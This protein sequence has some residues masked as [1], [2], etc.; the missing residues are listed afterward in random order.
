MH[1]C[2][3]SGNRNNNSVEEL[4]VTFDLI[5]L[6][7]LPQT[8]EIQAVNHSCCHTVGADYLKAAHTVI[9]L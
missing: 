7:F 6:L 3:A 2:T 4:K 8:L 5:V 9:A 1:A